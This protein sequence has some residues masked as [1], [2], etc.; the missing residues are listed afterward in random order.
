M[1]LAVCL[2]L[3][4]AV[5]AVFA[6]TLHYEFIDFDDSFYT[7]DNP[8]VAAGLNWKGV[9]WEFTHADCHIYH[10]L[11]MLSLMVDYQ[12]YGHHAGGY[13]FTNVLL[14]AT[15]A[16]LLFLVLRSM[17]GAFWRSAFVAA[18]FT[19]HPLRVES[20]AW[21]AER[22]DVLSGL[23]FMVTVGAYVLYVR[24]PWSFAR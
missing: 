14:H 6:R 18:I 10:P 5:W 12:L 3:A 17:T 24:R 2:F 16:V 19:V 7:Y 1:S 20:V 23:F 4:A 13:H 15:S 21:V 9:A 8:T 22:K 11:T